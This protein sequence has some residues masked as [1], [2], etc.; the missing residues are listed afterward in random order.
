MNGNDFKEDVHNLIY[1]SVV[2]LEG[3]DTNN[4][5]KTVVPLGM[6]YLPSTRIGGYRY[7]GML[8]E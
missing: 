8:G 1:S 7:S 5:V 4:P 6:G 2:V 3:L